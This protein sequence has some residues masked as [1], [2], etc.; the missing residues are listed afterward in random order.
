M[1]H[2]KTYKYF[3]NKIMITFI[4]SILPLTNMNHDDWQLI[5]AYMQ[6]VFMV[7]CQGHR[8]WCINVAE[9][10]QAHPRGGISK[11]MIEKHPTSLNLLWGLHNHQ[12]FLK[13]ESILST[14]P[15]SLRT[16]TLK[17]THT[18]DIRGR[19]S[20]PLTASCASLLIIIGTTHSIFVTYSCLS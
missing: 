14:S 19:A 10:C 15:Y 16:P 12:I 9:A 7:C 8:L 3:N 1:P 17:H 2:I 11:G 5:P 18:Q 20:K 13:I 6:H 4:F